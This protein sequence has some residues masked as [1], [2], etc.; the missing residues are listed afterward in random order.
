M[1]SAQQ[2]RTLLHDRLAD[3]QQL[4]Q[5]LKNAKQEYEDL[6]EKSNQL[7][8]ALQEADLAINNFRNAYVRSSTKQSEWDGGDL[9]RYSQLNEKRDEI[10]DELQTAE[11][12]REGLNE[13][14]GATSR[15]LEEFRLN[16]G[17]ED[18]E[19]HHT[20]IQKLTERATR[21]SDLIV[22][23]EKGIADAENSIPASPSEDARS[24]MLA[25]VALGEADVATLANLDA[26]IAVEL[27]AEKEAGEQVVSVVQD[28]EAT[29][30]GLRKILKSTQDDLQTLTSKTADLEFDFLRGEAETVGA[31]YVESAQAVLALWAQ[32]CALDELARD[33]R[34][35]MRASGAFRSDTWTKLYIPTFRVGACTQNAQWMR[36]GGL[37]NRSD[38]ER[39]V[40]AAKNRELQRLRQCGVSSLSEG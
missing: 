34:P 9:A 24:E 4:N 23:N 17:I 2:V 3:R 1:S 19:R 18:L 15:Q 13:T 38:F 30:I 31:A 6:S 7:R 25:Q 39:T 37:C 40:D 20:A 33:V 8:L 21:I 22:T 10:F 11:R 16:A 35:E 28:A 27:Q 29:I 26:S 32:L 5:T 14:I 36:F 12:R